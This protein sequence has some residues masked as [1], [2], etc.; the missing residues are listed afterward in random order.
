MIKDRLLLEGDMKPF[1]RRCE[2]CGSFNHLF[3]NCS[4]L[5]YNPNVDKLIYKCNQSTNQKRVR[6]H[7]RK[8]FKCKNALRHHK[9]I[10]TIAEDFITYNG[11]FIIANGDNDE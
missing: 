9:E 8:S 7:E 10:S 3:F 11:S 2:S 1:N 4:R 6:E 5:Q